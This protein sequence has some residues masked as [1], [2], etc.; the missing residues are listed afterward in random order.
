MKTFTKIMSF[1]LLLL[2]I[3]FTLLASAHY[4]N[5]RDQIH[6][7][8]YS[9]ESSYVITPNFIYN[10]FVKEKQELQ[11]QSIQNFFQLFTYQKQRIFIFR[12]KPSSSKIELLYKNSD[13]SSDFEADS[14]F[15]QEKRKDELKK[16]RNLVK[17]KKSFL[18]S[19]KIM[20][21]FV[22]FPKQYA[23]QYTQLNKSDYYILFLKKLNWWNPTY[24]ILYFSGFFFWLMLIFISRILY[25]QFHQAIQH[26]LK[27]SLSINKAENMEYPQIE[28]KISKYFPSI[29]KII[30]LLHE[31]H[32]ISLWQTSS[33]LRKQSIVQ[34]NNHLMINENQLTQIK[35]QSTNN[36]IVPDIEAL[37]SIQESY[38]HTK[39]TEIGASITT[40][41][42]TETHIFAYDNNNINNPNTYLLCLCN[43]GNKDEPDLLAIENTNKLLKKLSQNDTQTIQVFKET[44]QAI[45]K[46]FHPPKFFVAC[47]NLKEERLTYTNNTGFDIWFSSPQKLQIG[48]KSQSAFQLQ[49][50]SVSQIS[51]KKETFAICVNPNLYAELKM[52]S[53]LFAKKYIFSLTKNIQKNKTNNPSLKKLQSAIENIHKGK[54]IHNVLFKNIILISQKF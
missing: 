23:I 25:A 28:Y 50:I 22:M 29:K 48:T 6:N 24:Q 40:T 17:E 20:Y 5:I 14:Y 16:I 32:K 19:Q 15:N 31:I 54:E 49:S 2:I 52:T 13:P 8:I 45:F 39:Y 46:N 33:H 12:K 47:L 42:L 38:I 53:D 34:K 37:T 35:E 18:S 1:F 36:V 11:E 30:S 3:I 27:I 26:I 4:V 9:W 7:N 51:F 21:S 44:S 43:F 10:T 41:T